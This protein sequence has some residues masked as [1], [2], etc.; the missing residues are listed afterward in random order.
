MWSF[1]LLPDR[2][3]TVAGE[4]DALYYF[5]V[6]VSLFFS[7]VIVI[8]LVYS[9]VRYRKGSKASRA[10]AVHDNLKLELAWSIIPLF[11]SI[12]IFVWAARIF[13]DMHVAP[14]GAMEIY[15]VGK[16]WMWKVQHPEGNREINELHVPIGKPVRLIMT[17]QDVIHSFYI[18]A[19]RIK[20][21]V[22]P[23]RYS[24]QWFEATKTGEYHLFCAEYC[25]TS[26]S[27]M[28][29][30]VVVMEQA[31][32]EQWLSGAGSAT[33]AVTGEQ[34]FQ[35]YG[36][37]TCHKSGPTQRGPAL[38]GLFGKQVKLASG[39]TVTANEEYIRE[40]ILSPNKKLTQGYQPMMPTY[41]DQ[42]NQEQLN[43]IV[44]YVK[45][46]GAEPVAATR[47]LE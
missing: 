31:D 11:I 8:G 18:P 12:G 39:E 24:T 25:G 17:S 29:G 7:L 16:Q 34:L 22:L 2:A 13:F 37:Q 20:Q 45:S 27:G 1:P 33:M 5:L 43:H 47:K 41:K 28:I 21:D 46:L 4:I 14:P 44:E 36:C 26:H 40:S 3:S 6:M 42:L 30:K 19:F 9:A 35:Q 10:G 32:Y 15:V 23:G 38:V